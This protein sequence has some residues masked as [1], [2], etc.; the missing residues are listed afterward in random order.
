MLGRVVGLVVDTEDD[1]HVLVT[2]RRA[3]DHLLHAVV[4][5]RRRLRRVREEARRLDNQLHAHLTPGYLRRIAL[6][7]HL[8]RLAIDHQAAVDRL[9]A[10]L[11]AAVVTVVLQ[12]MGV[13]LHVHQVVDRHNL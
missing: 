6:G 13:R 1:C 12:K 5:M 7:E 9:N 11:E 3:D 10:A 2:R 8:D 4:T